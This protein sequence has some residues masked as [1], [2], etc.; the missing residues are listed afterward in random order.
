[1]HRDSRPDHG[2]SRSP[3]PA[4]AARVAAEQQ[5]PSNVHE[6]YQLLNQLFAVQMSAVVDVLNHRDASVHQQVESLRSE[7]HGLRVALRVLR[8]QHRAC[9]REPPAQA[10]PAQAGATSPCSTSAGGAGQAPAA[11]SA[12]ASAAG[13][14]V[15]GDESDGTSPAMANGHSATVA[16]SVAPASAPQVS[17]SR[18]GRAVSRHRADRDSGASHGGPAPPWHVER[19]VERRGSSGAGAGGGGGDTKATRSRG[20]R[21][22][23][24]R[25]RSRSPS[26]TYRGRRPRSSQQRPPSRDGTSRSR[27]PTRRVRCGCDDGRRGS[28][29]CA[30]ARA[31]SCTSAQ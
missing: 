7:V 4:A 12:G 1:M 27:S 8:A 29:N 26:P 24:S 11:R 28:A 2:S 15:P 3:E 16:A 9:V 13:V 5:L 30:C 14:S 23:R 18:G 19:H 17:C 20:A 6:F 21:R 10:R 25:S 31:C 22:S